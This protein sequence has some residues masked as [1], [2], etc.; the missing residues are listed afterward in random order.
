MMDNWLILK[1]MCKPVLFYS[2]V[3][4]NYPFPS[5]TGLI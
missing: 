2:A 1:L 3:T 5:I 4:V